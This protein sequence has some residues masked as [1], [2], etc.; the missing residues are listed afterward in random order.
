MKTWIKGGI[1]GI[2]AGYIFSTGFLIYA[3]FYALIRLGSNGTDM[4]YLGFASPILTPTLKFCFI[5]GATSTFGGLLSI[6]CVPTIV[7]LLFCII[8][9]LL[10]AI[11]GLIVQRIK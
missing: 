8:G 5:F 9:L 11:I 7:Y 6:L 1:I 4:L 3:L 10:R 2:I